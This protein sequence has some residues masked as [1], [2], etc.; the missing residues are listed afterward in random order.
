MR[1]DLAPIVITPRRQM[2]ELRVLLACLLAAAAVNLFAIIGY[3]TS[4]TE[5]VTQWRAML[6]VALA[7]YLT[8]A[9]SRGLIALVR[10]FIS[11]K[12]LST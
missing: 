1:L 9:A 11:Q 8:C 6:A 3:G 4:W 5:I 7:F 2:I 10:R 12:D